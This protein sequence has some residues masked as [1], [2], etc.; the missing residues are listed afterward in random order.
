MPANS[1]WDLIRR[2]RVNAKYNKHTIS[3]ILHQ[4]QNCK[5]GITISDVHIQIHNILFSSNSLTSFLFERASLL[6]IVQSWNYLC[7]LARFILSA[8]LGECFAII[9]QIVF[10]VIINSDILKPS[11]LCIFQINVLSF[12]SPTKCTISIIYKY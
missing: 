6:H 7:N 9:K 5:N 8:N 4:H 1:R 3:I 11:I 10:L 12:I 2:L